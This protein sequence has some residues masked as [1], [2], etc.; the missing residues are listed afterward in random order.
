MCFRSSLDWV[1][2]LA[3]EDL[4]MFLAEKLEARNKLVE[5]DLNPSGLV[6]KHDD[7]GHVDSVEPAL[8]KVK[9]YSDGASY[10]LGVHI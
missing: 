4:D 6:I 7:E 8:E 9:F 2:G 1:S 3:P 5:L 10:S